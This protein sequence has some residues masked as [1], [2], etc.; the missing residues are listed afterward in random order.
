MAAN[1]SAF[2]GGIV[3][4]AARKQDEHFTFQDGD[5]TIHPSRVAPKYHSLPGVTFT[6]HRAK[7]QAMCPGF[8]EQHLP[9][10]AEQMSSLEV[11]GEDEKQE[12]EAE[13]E[14]ETVDNSSSIVDFASSSNADLP[15][16]GA[17]TERS[18]LTIECKEDDRVI[19]ILLAFC[20]DRADL[21]DLARVPIK[22]RVGVWRAA[23]KYKCQALMLYVESSLM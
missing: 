8:V 10:L 6:V 23:V 14:G 3:S 19:K 4:P 21:L 20:Y 5:L 7:L 2:N 9:T 17:E 18:I 16:Q 13:A 15:D 12:G 1:V 11:W 22:Q